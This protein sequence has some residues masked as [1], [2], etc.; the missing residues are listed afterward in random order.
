MTTIIYRL[1]KAIHLQMLNDLSRPHDHA[2]ERIGFLFT[3]SKK[4]KD[5]SV[6]IIATEYIPV[7]DKQYIQDNE[8]GARINGDA[9]RFAM[10]KSRS[11]QCG[12]FHVHLHNHLGK[13]SMS[14]TD[15]DGIPPMIESFANV[16][17]EQSHGILILSRDSLMIDV[18]TYGE[19]DYSE[20]QP[21][22]FF[23]QQFNVL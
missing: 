9:I 21:L 13:P 17:P 16:A 8:V 4:L 22:N 6:L 5:G 12:V 11:E 7:P 23:F 1:P 20:P 2:A 15:K 10:Q 19:E 3:R 14:C 18:L